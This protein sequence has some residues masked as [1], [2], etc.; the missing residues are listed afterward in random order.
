MAPD[1]QNAGFGVYVHWPFCA[2]K[3]PYCD[4]NSH[5]RGQVDQDEWVVAYKAEIAEIARLTGPRTVSTVF[6]GGG[7]PS[8]M[9]PRTVGAVLDAISDAWTLSN[10]AEV[11]LE[12]NPTS[13]EAGRFRGYATAGVNRASLGIQALNDPDLRALGRMHSAHEA[14]Q[15]IEIAQNTFSQTS[16]DLIYARQNQSA[17]EWELELKQAL[18]LAADHLSLYQLTIEPQTRFGHMHARG[19]LAGL[20]S[21][22]LGAD[23]YELTQDIC[24]DHGLPAY[25]VSNHATDAAQCKHN[26]IYWRYGDFAG[27]GPGAHGRLTLDSTR[28]ATSTEL[29]P[30]KWLETSKSDGI[31]CT[32]DDPISPVEQSEEYLMMG[33]RL[34]EGVSIRRLLELRPGFDVNSPDDLIKDGFLKIDGD[35]L[36]ATQTG[37]LVLNS[38]L[39]ALLTDQDP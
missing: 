12:A 19:R 3:C 32:F 31:A 26:L 25:E 7:T 11:S 24:E 9:E 8:L 27:I 18:N 39:G 30:E 10:D 22:D 15:A 20:P 6:L 35:R 23:L 13:V 5:V 2:A 33:L 17:G 1:W 16:F 36:K 29:L 4:F 34:V 37:R 14:M 21:D 28:W 38:I